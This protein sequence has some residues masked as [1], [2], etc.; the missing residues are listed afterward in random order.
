MVLAP[1]SFSI[2]KHSLEVQQV[3]RDKSAL[4]IEDSTDDEEPEPEP[5]DVPPTNQEEP[6]PDVP[7]ITT[8]ATTTTTTTTTTTDEPPKAAPV[9]EI[10]DPIMELIDLT[11]DLEEK[12]DRRG[13]T[14]IISPES[15]LIPVL[16]AED[17][18]KDKLA[19]AAREKLAAKNRALQLERKKR[20]AAFLSQLKPQSSKH[21]NE[22]V[23]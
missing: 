20:A 4:P 9:I 1:V 14:L 21:D 15:Q 18:V 22:E 16:S 12:R 6:L 8:T 5:A 19:L 2:K 17:R 7:P 10:E 13:T 11:E 23:H 3:P